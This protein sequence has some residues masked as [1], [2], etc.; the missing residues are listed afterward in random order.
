MN[1]Y[2]FTMNS[3]TQ[4]LGIVEA[5]LHAEG[6]PCRSNSTSRRLG[7]DNNRSHFLSV[8]ILASRLMGLDLG[9]LDD[10]LRRL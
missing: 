2:G 8:Q 4:T 3:T 5:L 7:G 10:G 9:P 1:R 6:R